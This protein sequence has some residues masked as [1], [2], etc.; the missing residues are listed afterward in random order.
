M[1][2][3]MAQA[4]QFLIIG[5][6]V[7]G[8]SV[9][10]FLHRRGISFAVAD[11]S[12]HPSQHQA[13]LKFASDTPVYTGDIKAAY[14]EQAEQLIVSPGVSLKTLRA[15]TA[16]K[17]R[18]SFI[19]DIELFARYAPPCPIAAITGTNGKSTVASLLA[20]A[21][22]CAGLNVASGGNLAGERP[23][24]MPALDLIE[25]YKDVELYVLELSSFQ[26]Q[27]I[28]SLRPSV[29]VILNIKPD[30]LD[31]HESFA[32]YH[33]AK[34]RIHRNSAVVVVNREEQI[35]LQIEGAARRVSFGLD[36]APS[37]HFGVIEKD[38]L[39]H[40]AY[41]DK[42]LISEADIALVGDMGLLNTQAMFAMGHA[43]G[44]PFD[45]MCSAASSFHS[46]AHRLQHIGCR[47]GVDWYNDSKATNVSATCAALHS[48]DRPVVLIAGGLGKGGDFKPLV[49]LAETKVRAVVLLGK[50]AEQIAAAMEGR[51]PY[52]RVENMEQA[53]L[54]AAD[55]AH[56][57]DCVLL[58]PACASLDMYR[59][60]KERGEAFRSAYKK[61]SQ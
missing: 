47:N 34:L 8:L 39:R 54:C 17:K 43:L 16:N 4:Y 35:A 51:V 28:Y 20:D 40:I 30:H 22:K 58:S 48:I 2:K 45:A 32:D 41:G 55:T 25:Q 59:N 29:S 52:I 21:A 46:L 38:G 42:L 23:Q 24:S 19:G 61:L 11:N 56:P 49:D 6:G 10:R 18:K 13:L 14:L 53:V 3:T 26:L 60:Y 27:T 31:H 12:D 15:I 44:L 7:T 57:G 50:D 36:Q 33:D 1:Y 37:G 5:L 9:A